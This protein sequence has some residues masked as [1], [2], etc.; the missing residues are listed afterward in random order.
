MCS[1][2][3]CSELEHIVSCTNFRGTGNE[4]PW[5]PCYVHLF[6]QW[7]RNTD[8]KDDHVKVWSFA[9]DKVD[10]G[11]CSLC[12]GASMVH[13]YWE[14]PPSHLAGSHVTHYLITCT[15]PQSGHERSCTR[16][17]AHVTTHV[18]NPR[19]HASWSLPESSADLCASI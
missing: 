13:M 11:S 10:V 17:N 14:I 15:S 5:I 12:I 9:F 8:F 3:W 2:T 7:I 4:C 19:R 6:L 18:Q 16:E 1:W